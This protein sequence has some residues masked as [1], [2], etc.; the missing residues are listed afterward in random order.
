MAELL[1]TLLKPIL[2]KGATIVWE[3]RN[4]LTTYFKTK[5]G[6]YKNKD[7]RFSISYLFKIQIPNTNKYLLVK[8]RRIENQ[9][10]PVG[11]AYKR[12]GDDSLFNKWEYK[13]DNN[14]NGL[15]VDEKSASDLRFMV[16]GKFAIEVMNWFESMQER[17]INPNR[18]FKEE[19]L[20]TNILDSKIFQNIN[21]KHI[22]RFS[23][24]LVW[25]EF[26]SCYEV[27]VYDVFELIPNK[28]Q[29]LALIELNK[30]GTNLN[31][32]YAIVDCDNIEQL[33]Y[34]ENEKQVARIGQHTKLI[35][36]KTF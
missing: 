13:P 16:K 23:K 17:E 5:I 26:F 15:N 6:S 35:I 2:S 27:L 7:I 8:N 31:K 14:R 24:N 11:G 1:T 3:N 21:Y 33:R 18:E 36:N 25:S 28:E 34:M 30:I 9:L 29:K 10:Q 32:D 12:Y 20:D 22:R 19:L 4:N